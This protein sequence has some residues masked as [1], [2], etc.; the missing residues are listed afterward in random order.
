MKH[1]AF[2]SSALAEELHKDVIW[3]RVGEPIWRDGVVQFFRSISFSFREVESIAIFGSYPEVGINW[4]TRKGLLDGHDNHYY[5]EKDT[6]KWLDYMAECLANYANFSIPN[7]ERITIPV[8]KAYAYTYDGKYYHRPDD[9]YD[10]ITLGQMEE[11]PTDGRWN[12]N[13]IFTSPGVVYDYAN[14]L[15]VSMRDIYVVYKG[16][17]YRQMINNSAAI[18]IDADEFFKRFT[19]PHLQSNQQNE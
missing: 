4:A 11:I 14:D 6:D 9:D 10:Q 8:Y 15:G 18:A 7:D 17:L 5:Q 16:Q 19:T 1:I 13:R 2:A 12:Y 3:A